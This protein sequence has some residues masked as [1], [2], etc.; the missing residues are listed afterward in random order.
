MLAYAIKLT[1][2]PGDMAQADVV[3]LR[4]AGF[5]DAALLDV[6]QVVAYYNYVN[7]LADGLGVELEDF[8]DEGDLIVTREEFEEAR[9]RPRAVDA[10]SNASGPADSPS[11]SRAGGAP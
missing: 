8:W 9:G 2:T 11:G 3:A 1:L 10:A 6:C 4:E 7:R 5:E